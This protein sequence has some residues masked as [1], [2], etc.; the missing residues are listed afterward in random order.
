MRS[1]WSVIKT[2]PPREEI[3]LESFIKRQVGGRGEFLI[4]LPSLGILCRSTRITNISEVAKEC[5]VVCESHISSRHAYAAV[6]TLN[7]K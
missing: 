1:L 2:R 4:G 5:E 7:T 3:K 6:Y